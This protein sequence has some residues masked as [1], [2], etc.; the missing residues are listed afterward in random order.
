M[1]K[2][3]SPWH[4]HAHQPVIYCCAQEAQTALGTCLSMTSALCSSSGHT[5]ASVLQVFCV[6]GLGVSVFS[7]NLSQ[8]GG[9]PLFRNVREFK[10]FKPTTVCF[11][12]ILGAFLFFIKWLGKNKL[13]IPLEKCIVDLF[14]PCFP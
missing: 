12:F 2:Q 1:M 8:V 7:Q 13:G 9:K 10:L 4:D 6:E 5:R 11:S 14:P 3:L